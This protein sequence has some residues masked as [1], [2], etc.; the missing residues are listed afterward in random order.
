M[1]RTGLTGSIASGKS[2]VARI[3]VALGI[4]VFDAD[5]A[6]HELYEDGTA[7]AVLVP[8]FSAAVHGKKVDRKALAAILLQNPALFA[9]L[10]ALVHPLV[11]Q[12]EHEFFRKAELAG[13]KLA[14]A[15]IPLLFEGDRKAD[16]DVVVVVVAPEVVR[17]K[18]AL[19]R[20]GMTP[21]K[22]DTIVRRQWP[23]DRKR[24]HADIVIDNDGSLDELEARTKALLEGLRRQE[25]R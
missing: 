7:A 15:D 23:D 14:M 24:Q 18:R 17:R 11:R 13:E 9:E 10:E 4:P 21:E 16:F 3:A 6:V 12:K 19:Q 20:P 25:E 5:R 8:V 2:E 22:F 1:K